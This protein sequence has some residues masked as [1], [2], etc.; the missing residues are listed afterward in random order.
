MFD[1][2]FGCVDKCNVDVLLD[3]GN[4]V[5]L[6]VVD[7]NIRYFL[8]DAYM[9]NLSPESWG[10]QHIIFMDFNMNEYD[11]NRMSVALIRR[12][13]DKRE[14]DFCCNMMNAN[15]ENSLNSFDL[16]LSQYGLPHNIIR[17]RSN[18]FTII[19]SMFM[20]GNIPDFKSAISGI[21]KK[22][23]REV[24]LDYI[25]CETFCNRVSFSLTSLMTFD[26]LDAI[27][28]NGIKMIDLVDE[29]NVATI[30]NNVVTSIIS[31]GINTNKLF[32]TPTWEE[33]D[34]FM[35]CE[36]DTLDETYYV[37]LYLALEKIMEHE[38]GGNTE[39]LYKRLLRL[40][41]A[42]NN[43]KPGDMLDHILMV[44][45]EQINN[46]CGD[47]LTMWAKCV[48][49]YGGEKINNYL[50]EYLKIRNISIEDDASN[51]HTFIDLSAQPIGPD[52]FG[53]VDDVLDT[54]EFIE[55]EEPAESLY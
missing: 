13:R 15:M 26:Y 6:S 23:V 10:Y 47:I 18:K 53:Y 1:Y 11:P 22:D 37:G 2:L 27:Y 34:K 24:I 50:N 30:I 42:S 20:S 54:D 38:K 35:R 46:K 45:G 7:E 32:K 17:R 51:E 25:G 21:S 33:I 4:K 31:H 5:V 8:G 29:S 49:R 36:L 48:K 14:E 9:D 55:E 39:R 16:K 43:I 19:S 12:G 44:I 40:L 28:D 3:K 41:L 52:T